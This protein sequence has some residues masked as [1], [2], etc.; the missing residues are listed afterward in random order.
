M[1]GDSING[2]GI[3]DHLSENNQIGNV[4]ADFLAS[5]GNWVASLLGIRNLVIFEIYDK[6]F[7]IRFLMKSMPKS[8][9]YGKRTTDNFLGFHHMNPISS[10]CVHPVNLWLYFF[11]KPTADHRAARADL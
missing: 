2:F 8:I 10:I 7:F 4:F 1:I 6:C 11:F 3:Y 9:Q 5:V